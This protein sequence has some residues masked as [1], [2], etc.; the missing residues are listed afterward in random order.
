MIFYMH[1]LIMKHALWPVLKTSM[2][3]DFSVLVKEDPLLIDGF[4]YK[5]DGQTV[6]NLVI[7]QF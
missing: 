3:F 2:M 4:T 5:E 6:E 7:T 1:E